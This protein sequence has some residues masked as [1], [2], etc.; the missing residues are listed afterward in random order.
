MSSKILFLRHGIT[1][2]NKNKW[3]YGALDLPLL[4]EGKAELLDCKN[5]G[6]Y[7]DVP[8]NTMYFT[9]GLIRTEETLKVIFGDHPFQ[10]IPELQEMNFGDLEGKNYDELKDNADFLAWM[11]DESGSIA[12]PGGESRNDFYD[13]IRRG[14]EA[15]I[16]KHKASEEELPEDE[17]AFSVMICHGGVIAFIMKLLFPDERETMWDWMIEP[18]SGYLV[19]F[20]KG[21]PT[22]HHLIGETGVNYWE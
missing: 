12:F 3:F 15:L 14:T 6:Y 16:E 1:E 9:T 22:G 11:Q 5:K 8:D 21:T 13:R 2:G 18:A 4:E 17:D 19:E 7:P 20:E 10:K